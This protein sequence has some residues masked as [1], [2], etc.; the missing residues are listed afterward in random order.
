MSEPDTG[1]FRIVKNAEEISHRSE[2]YCVKYHT[3]SEDHAARTS[4]GVRIHAIGNDGLS[5]PAPEEQECRRQF[6]VF[7]SPLSGGRGSA[8][9]EESCGVPGRRQV[10]CLLVVE[11]CYVCDEIPDAGVV[12]DLRCFDDRL[13]CRAPVSSRRRSESFGKRFRCHRQKRRGAEETGSNVISGL[14]LLVWNL[15]TG[16]RPNC[17][18]QARASHQGTP[19]K[20]RTAAARQEGNREQIRD[21][22]QHC[23]VEYIDVRLIGCWLWQRVRIR[24]CPREEPAQSACDRRQCG[25]GHRRKE[26]SGQDRPNRACWR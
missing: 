4:S 22:Q 9:W 20:A 24:V 11:G 8:D 13:R 26:N 12:A 18:E 17:S 5:L 21:L 19:R 6:S 14:Q 16:R 15:P 10:H 7:P 23:T 1:R 25:L 2:V 3:I